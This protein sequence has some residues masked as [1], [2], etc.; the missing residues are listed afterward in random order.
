MVHARARVAHGHLPTV[1]A[2]NTG[3]QP[4][5]PALLVLLFIQV[6]LCLRQ[7]LLFVPRDDDLDRPSLG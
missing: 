2:D 6:E 7:F 4:L 1:T 3:V 5:V